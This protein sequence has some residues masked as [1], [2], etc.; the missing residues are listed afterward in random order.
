[1]RKGSG[2][3]VQGSGFRVQ[4]PRLRT[5]DSGLT[6]QES[7][8]R[9]QG[10][11]ARPA[12]RRLVVGAIALACAGCPD[13]PGG[14]RPPLD[15][16]ALE[17]S[18][19]IVNENLGRAGGGLRASGTVTGTY[20]RASGRTHNLGLGMK[21]ELSVI[22]PLHMRFDITELGQTQ[23]LFGSNTNLYWLYI[24]PDQ[25]TYRWGHYDD[26]ADVPESDLPLRPDQLIEAIGLNP[27]PETATDVEL[28]GLV[29]RIEP[30]WQQLLFVPPGSGGEPV[31]TKEYWLERFDRRL[32]R[33]I[34]F[35]DRMGR[36]QMRASL[37]AYRAIRDGGPWLPHR[38]LVEWPLRRGELDYR[39]LRW[40]EFE[41]LTPDHPA[42]AAPHER[43]LKFG[44]ML[45]LG[46]A[47]ESNGPQ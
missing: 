2:F 24:R 1:M 29:Q 10:S 25:D 23:I 33:Q 11:A 46:T 21:G 12:R 27:L 16:I 47:A 8:L 30:D 14:A 41:E 44:R 38:V 28:A 6:T 37:D 19:S 5:Q 36:V 43:G 7:G 26:I 39:I 4:G 35:R 31:L 17:Q 40:R 45:P 22:P 32:L 42:F 9:T 15:V 3:R 18:V 20:V 13:G 34:L